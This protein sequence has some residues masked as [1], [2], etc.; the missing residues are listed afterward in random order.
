MKIRTASSIV[1]YVAQF[2][3]SHFSPKTGDGK[4]EVKIEAFEKQ[5]EEQ[6]ELTSFGNEGLVCP[7]CGGPAKRMGNCAIFCTSCKQTTRNG[8]GE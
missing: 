1:D 2:M 6:L 3:L 8:C 4:I 7:H 5:K